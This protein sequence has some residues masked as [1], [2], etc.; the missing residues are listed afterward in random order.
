MDHLT[1]QIC[2]QIL[3][4]FESAAI[5]AKWHKV[6]SNAPIT[7]T[8]LILHLNEDVYHCHNAIVS[9]GLR[10]SKLFRLSFSNDIDLTLLLPESCHNMWEMVLNFMHADPNVTCT[11]ATVVP[12][13]KIAHVLRISALASLCVTWL[14]NHI[15]TSTN[16][17]EVLAASISFA[18]GLEAIESVCEHAIARKI[19][20]IQ[21][22]RLSM[23]S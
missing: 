4:E 14:R 20:T 18:P 2:E 10:S 5:C 17:F 22:D 23:K 15:M 8:L 12:L 7:A 3:T 16:A 21:L 13:F 11:A 6:G 1:N 19:N 9:H